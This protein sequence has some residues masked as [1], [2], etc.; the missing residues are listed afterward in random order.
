MTTVLVTGGAGIIGTH[1]R[2]TLATA[3]RRLRLMDVAPMAPV[4][5]GEPVECVR[6]SFLDAAALD[7]ACRGV[8]AIIH[9]GALSTG[10]YALS[11]YL[12]VNV[13][14]THEVLEAARRAKVARVVFASSHHVLGRHE[15]PP[16]GELGEYLYP[17]PDSY[18]GVS[19]VAGEALCRLAHDRHGLDVLCLRIGSYRERPREHRTRWNWLSPGDCTRLFEAALD[20]RRPGFRVVWGVSANA[21][22]IMSLDEAA[23]IGYRPL[24]D[25]SEHA[26]EV[27]ADAAPSALDQ[28]IGGPFAAPGFDDPLG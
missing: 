8:S 13:R 21:G 23:A 14:G 5:P 27:L 16:E 11:D 10:G 6:A 20:A 26:L 1:L 2:A 22:R 24:D 15:V 4:A 3:G 17:Q 25:A 19:K 9:L 7:E 12:E 28:F 18:Y